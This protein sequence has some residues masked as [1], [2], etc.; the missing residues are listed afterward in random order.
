MVICIVIAVIILIVAA[1]NARKNSND[2][3]AMSL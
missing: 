2:I 3:K 1:V